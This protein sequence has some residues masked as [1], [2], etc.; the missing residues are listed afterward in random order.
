[1]LDTPV[2]LKSSVHLPEVVCSR[3]PEYP[4]YRIAAN[5][6]SAQIL[7]CEI[8]LFREKALRNFGYNI[9]CVIYP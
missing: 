4:V 9:Y 2:T 5:N 7:F 1:M 6:S 3:F 8:M